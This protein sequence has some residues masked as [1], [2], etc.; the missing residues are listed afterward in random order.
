MSNLPDRLESFLVLTAANGSPSVIRDYLE[1][2]LDAISRYEPTV[3]AFVEADLVHARSLADAA[4]ARRRA[5]RRLSPI[6]GMPIGIKDIIATSNLPTRMGTRLSWQTEPAIDAACMLAARRGG[7]IPLGKLATTQFAIGGAAADT[8]NPHN[9]EHT[10]GG[11]SSG[12]AAAT[13]SGMVA[14]AFGTQTQGSIIRPASFC[15]VVGYKPSFGALSLRGVHP[16][17]DTLDHL[18]VLAAHFEDAWALVRWCAELAPGP[19]A[20]ALGKA[21]EAPVASRPA[22]LGLLATAGYEELDRKSLAAFEERITCLQQAGAEVIR[23]EQ[24][25]QLAELCREL[26]SIPPISLELIGYEM[27]WPY[28]EYLAGDRAAELDSRIIE[29][30]GRGEATSRERAAEIYAIQARLGKLVACAAARYEAFILPAGSGPAPRRV[31][32]T[33]SRTNLVYATFLGLPAFSLPL[34]RV[35]GMPFGLQVVGLA[36]DDLRLAGI[37]R[38]MLAAE[39]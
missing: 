1:R 16:V 5:G 21:Q 20:T 8:R 33:G 17:A 12:S 27:C 34:M 14:A 24:D 37:A 25:S 13:A 36:R 23:P 2:C 22:R 6:D 4:D 29:L 35:G 30:V 11:S 18:G 31:Q 19:A 26:D 7:A 32:N 39:S 10:P 15:G 38:W 9:L 28:S 3:R